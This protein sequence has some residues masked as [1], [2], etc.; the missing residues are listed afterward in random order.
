MI[1]FLLLFA[2]LSIAMADDWKNGLTLDQLDIIKTLPI[3][4]KYST[5][6]LFVDRRI[7]GV[8]A[9]ADV[10][11]VRRCFRAQHRQMGSYCGKTRLRAFREGSKLGGFSIS[12]G[13]A[14]K[15]DG[16]NGGERWSFSFVVNF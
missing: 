16:K 5:Y 8:G 13:F 4:N 2:L 9:H 15:V 14:G 11:S 7:R 10:Q 12:T 1:F 3:K 6:Y